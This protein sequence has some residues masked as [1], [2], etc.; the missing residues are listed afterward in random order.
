MD[1][2]DEYIEGGLLARIDSLALMRGEEVAIITGSLPTPQG[3]FV[4]NIDEQSVS[5][6][7]QSVGSSCDFS[8]DPEGITYTELQFAYQDVASQLRFRCGVNKGDTVLLCCKGCV[9][10]EVVSMLACLKLGVTFVPVDDSWM[11]VGTRLQDIIEDANPAAALVVAENDTD[12]AVTALAIAGLYRCIYINTNG[13]I[14]ESFNT[15]RDNNG[16]A[17]ETYSYD[18]GDDVATE[19]ALLPAAPSDIPLYILYTSGS[20]GRPKGVRGTHTGLLNR[21]AWQLKTFPFQEGEVVCRRTPLV[22]VDAMAEIFSALVGMVD[23]WCPPR[24]RMLAEGIGGVAAQAN[25]SGVSRLTLLPS[26]LQQALILHPNLAEIW[27]ALRIV[28]VSGEECTAALVKLMKERLPDVTLVNLYGSTEV[29]GDVSYAVLHTGLYSSTQ[30][31][32]AIPTASTDDVKMDKIPI[33]CALEGNHIFIVN[34]NEADKEFRIL[35]D[36]EVGEVMVVGKHVADGYHNISDSTIASGFIP[37]PLRNLSSVE[38]DGMDI[39]D[40]CDYEYA[41]LMGDL[42]YRS[43]GDGLLYLTGRKDRQVKIRGIRLELEDVERQIGLG[44]GLQDSVVVLAV[45]TYAQNTSTTTDSDTTGN[46]N[47]ISGAS[48]N[49]IE[50]ATTTATAT[51]ATKI[52]VLQLEY[53]TIHSINLPIA[54]IKEKLRALLIPA[55]VP[56]IVLPVQDFP[57]TTSGKIDRRL[58]Q[59]RLEEL[60]P[61]SIEYNQSTEAITNINNN[62]KSDNNTTQNNQNKKELI[63]EI[64]NLTHIELCNRMLHLF[65]DILGIT[66]PIN[67]SPSEIDFYQLG[68]DSVRL[69]EVLWRLR[70]WTTGTINSEDLQQTIEKLAYQLHRQKGRLLILCF[71]LILYYDICVYNIICRYSREHASRTYR[72]PIETH[73]VERF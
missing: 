27:P 10:A 73:Q 18:N 42:G 9:V 54:S 46:S 21:I 70:Q 15:L 43:A 16:F 51:G 38:K 2:I 14:V 17:V 22:F 11:N 35:V 61:R 56:A 41:F 58:M 20:T 65:A 71:G 6:E 47:T 66:A 62:Q 32:A 25:E 26:Q 59:A 44:L 23:L 24:D 52:L 3:S 48:N 72:K 30:T 49:S 13:E 68:G 36:D 29:A 55:M 69:I 37:N 28:F 5:S 45:D 34:Y 50:H 40:A 60:L 1:E 8:I 57:R 64:Q 7:D 53:S 4:P 31:L 39:T 67:V 19:D 33:G 63:S 12:Y